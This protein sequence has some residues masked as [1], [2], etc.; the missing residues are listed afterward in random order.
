LTEKEHVIGRGA[1]VAGGIRVTYGLK[2]VR[3]SRSSVV[4]KI[5]LGGRYE[6]SRPEVRCTRLAKRKWQFG[7]WFSVELEDGTTPDIRFAG[8]NDA[9]VWA[10]QDMGWPVQI[11]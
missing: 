1:I 10:F 11:E 2:E 6:F 4:I 8:H 9:T 3:I 5:F 7:R